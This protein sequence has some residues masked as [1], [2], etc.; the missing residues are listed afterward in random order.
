MNY[1]SLAF[2]D[3]VRDMQEKLGSRKSYARL[4]GRSYVD[5]LTENEI[6]FISDRDSFYMASIGENG[7][8]YIQHRG[9]PKGFIKVLNTKQLGFI[10]YKGNAQ[11]ITVGNIATHNNVALIMV[12]YPTRTRLKLYARAR[13]VELGDDEALLAKL[14]LEGYEFR[15]ERMM[16]FDVEAYDWN[17]QQHITPRYSLDEIN[18]AFASQRKYISQLEAEVKQLKEQLAAGK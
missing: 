16:L 17:C 5:G 12:D 6:S 14:D 3:A 7:Y 13:I 1:A 10:D 2:T 15:P 8:P 11:Y 18:K 4:E 9:G